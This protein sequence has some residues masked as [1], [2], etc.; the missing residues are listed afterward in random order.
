MREYRYTT[1]HGIQVTRT[2]SKANFRKGLQHLL[3]DL[4]HGLRLA[5]S[6]LRQDGRNFVQYLVSIH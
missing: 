1:P 3:R 5:G 6:R 2:V 4:D